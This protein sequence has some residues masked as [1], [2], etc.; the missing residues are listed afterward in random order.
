MRRPTQHVMIFVLII[1]PVLSNTDFGP[2]HLARN[3]TDSTERILSI[4]YW[5]FVNNLLMGAIRGKLL[6]WLR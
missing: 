6:G 4:N 3:A 1:F 5:I 2:V